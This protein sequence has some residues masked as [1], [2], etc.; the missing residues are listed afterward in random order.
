MRITVCTRQRYEDDETFRK[1]MALARKTCI[2]AVIAAAEELQELADIA[3]ERGVED[4]WAKLDVA[5][6]WL[7]LDRHIVEATEVIRSAGW[8]WR[9]QLASAWGP[10][11]DDV[12]VTLDSDDRIEPEYLVTV[13]SHWRPGKTELRSWQPIKQRLKDGRLHRHRYRYRVKGRVSPFY[14]V[15][16]PTERVHAYVVSHGKLH[17]L[18]EPIWMRDPGAIAVIHGENAL[19]DLRAGDVRIEAPSRADYR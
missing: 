2:P 12:Q 16:N 1:R 8:R 9:L 6:R 7:V 19:M 4:R 5:W 13:A 18:I 17:E 11:D 3:L 15:Y 14:A 10:E